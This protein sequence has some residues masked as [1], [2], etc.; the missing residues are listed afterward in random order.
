MKQ[1]I[2]RVILFML[3]LCLALVF[4][5]AVNTSADAATVTYTTH[6]VYI[7]GVTVPS[8]GSH[9][10][11]TITGAPTNVIINNVEW[12]DVKTGTKMS[13]S[14]KFYGNGTYRVDITVAPLPNQGDYVY[15]LGSD[16]TGTINGVSATITTP[17]SNSSYRVLSRTFTLSGTVVNR[18][19]LSITEPVGKS[20]PDKNPIDKLGNV[21]IISTNWYITYGGV[22]IPIAM[23]DNGEFI[24]TNAYMVEIIIEPKLDSNYFNDAANMTC[25]IN[26]ADATITAV[27]GNSRQRCVSCIF[28]AANYVYDSISITDVT[29]PASGNKPDWNISTAT[30]D[31][32]VVLI[33]W[34]DEKNHKYISES[35]TTF[36]FKAGGIYTLRVY[37]EAD[38]G[39]DFAYA[40]DMTGTLKTNKRTANC[41]VKLEDYY[42]SNYVDWRYIEYTFTCPGTTLTSIDISGPTPS[43]GDT[44]YS[45]SSYSAKDA[46]SVCTYLVWIDIT[47][48][49]YGLD[50]GTKFIAGL[51]YTL[52]MLFKPISNGYYFPYGTY[53]G[54]GLVPY[55]GTVTFNGIT[56]ASSN[57]KVVYENGYAIDD[58]EGC[59]QVT[60]NNIVVP[61]QIST[62]TATG[63]TA[64]LEGNVPNFSIPTIAE[65]G[66]SVAS[67]K[68]L[69]LDTLNYMASTEKFVAGKA[70]RCNIYLE[71]STGYE[72][73]DALSISGKINGKTA[74]VTS[75]GS[76]Q[77]CIAYD[78]VAAE[79][80]VTAQPPVIGTQPKGGSYYVGDSVT[81]S[82]KASVTDGGTLS[83][84]WYKTTVN[85]ISTIKA[86]YKESDASYGT[87]ASF[88]PEQT[89]GTTYYC[90]M[91]TNT[92][93]K[94]GKKA[95]SFVYSNLVA[96][97]FSEK[98]V[99]TKIEVWELPTKV[100]YKQGETFD[101]TGLVL[102]L[103]MSDGGYLAGNNFSEMTFSPMTLN[104]TG[105]Q[106][107]T[108]TYQGKTTTFNVTVN[109]VHTHS[110]GTEWKN[111]ASQHWHECSCGEKSGVADHTFGEWNVT[112]EATESEK[113]LKERTCSACGYKETEEI[114]TIAHEHKAG[115]EWKNDSTSHWNECTCGEKM[116][117]SDHTFG[118]WNVT[119]EATEEEK[120]LKERTCSVCGFKETE[121]IPLLAH[122][123]KAGSEWKFDSDSHWNECSCG[124]KM[125]VADHTFGDWVVTK[126]ET[127]TETGLK[128]RTCSVCG[129]KETR[130][131]P[132]EG[133]EHTA[134]SEWESNKTSHWHECSC[135][136]EM[137]V[138]EHTFG[139]WTVT[140]E[141]TETEKGLKER[142]CAVCGYKE[143]EDIP[144]T[145][146]GEKKKGGFPWWLI[147]LAAVLVA[148]GIIIFI[149][150]GKKKKKD[151]KQ[152]QP[153][154][155]QT[156]KPQTENKP[157]ENKT[158]G[159]KTQGKKKQNKKK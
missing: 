143:T 97:T 134:G 114:P 123:H 87:K 136:E 65:S 115:S 109:A 137:D 16:L 103:H 100:V 58:S 55:T 82:V 78:F 110:F 27:D 7:S 93:T 45:K 57:V 126:E 152:P 146:P 33:K 153:A 104:T 48:N 154:N 91:V 23:A 85:D 69:N 89:V 120:G 37:V 121:E 11:T 14:D 111:N 151:E 131:I 30:S 135:G 66:M 34:I 132:L 158:Q 39:Y 42:D 36:S 28:T 117:V 145:Q 107:I 144:V 62:I 133:H 127:E 157:Q 26:D 159:N 139:E 125:N 60:I 150:L 41:Q 105:T 140:K 141:A 75:T 73:L 72:F 108:V 81:L 67:V 71:A 79:L 46:K 94:N 32:D 59:L 61:Y 98:I 112:K 53:S 130:E 92:V 9:P 68:W 99:L 54:N 15:K 18:A 156:E 113:G 56:V 116:N 17:A 70:Y 63:V 129:F 80:P 47:A 101:P 148:A 77:I 49:T 138:E 50:A 35:D 29:E 44:I 119:K 5:T 10:V 25:K 84:Q 74:T 83:Y 96:V 76:N 31:Y 2:K 118:E 102:K 6:S 142:T 88:V 13:S 64:P 147:I 51:E 90:V 3:P 19:K 149:V 124:E 122:E 22:K 20:N 106:T 43:N 38:T 24:G 52:I 21:K 1:F 40:D 8:A 4:A 86:I 12:Y 95:T 128:E 155:S